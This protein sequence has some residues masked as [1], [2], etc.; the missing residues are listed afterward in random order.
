MALEFKIE[1]SGN[2]AGALEKDAQATEHAEGAT[3]KHRK[4]LELFEGEIGKAKASLG[5]FGFNLEAFSKGGSL[6]TFDLAEG[7]RS[8]VDLAS[9]VTEKIIDLGKEMVRSAAGAEDLGLAIKLDVGEEGAKKINEL[10]ESFANSRFS[11]AQIKEAL[12]P[13]LEQGQTDPAQ[14]NDMATAATDIAARRKSGLAGVNAALSAFQQIGLRREVNSRML[15]ELSINEHDFYADLG[16]LLG[17]SAEQAKAQAQ[18]GK[19]QSKTLLSVALNQI[20]QREGGAL[21]T[22][23]N[24][25]NKTLGA[26]LDRLTN[27]KDEIPAKLAG[28]QGM[29][30]LQG[31]LDTFVDTLEGPV[32]TELVNTIDNAFLTL[33]GDLS[34]P[35]GA[36]KFEGVIIDVTNDIR[37]MV[38]WFQKAWPD[39]KAG[40]EDLWSVLKDIGKTVGTIVDGW[41]QLHDFMHDVDTGR[42]YKDVYDTVSGEHGGIAKDTGDLAA[43]REKNKARLDA[44]AG[45]VPHMAAG[46]IVDRPTLAL[47][48][49]AGPEAVMPLGRG[50]AF[51]DAIGESSA[52]RGSGDITYSP[53][54]HVGGGGEVAAVRDQLEQF[55]RQARLE[56]KKILDELRAA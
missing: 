1:L 7:L 5:G 3:K 31:A 43:W 45:D 27:L 33:F 2:F 32:G 17:V 23:T 52:S 8:V 16:G 21:G 36:K 29:K 12:L 13:L 40:A 24:E 25:G 47:V 48:G 30:A 9:E 22:A 6:F 42:I 20:A 39:I 18:K 54:Y 37:D 15:R 26:T 28:G 41:K 51:S 44:M 38:S 55:D 34:G 14:L 50:S 35:E 19:L 46:G 53:Q 4:E 49:E 56:F 10:G 11:P